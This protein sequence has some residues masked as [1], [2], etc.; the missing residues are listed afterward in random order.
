M[1]YRNVFNPD[2]DSQMSD[3]DRTAFMKRRLLMIAAFVLAIG[4]VAIFAS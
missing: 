2:F 3:A 4:G 1:A